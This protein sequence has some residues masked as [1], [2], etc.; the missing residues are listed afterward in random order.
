MQGNLL[1]CYGHPQVEYSNVIRIWIL[2]IFFRLHKEIWI[3][4]TDDPS[5]NFNRYVMYFWQENNHIA[6]EEEV[7][8][9]LSILAATIRRPNP[10]LDT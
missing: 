4:N 1:G 9:F 3:H 5:V 10:L 7:L 8:Y 2:C 6:G